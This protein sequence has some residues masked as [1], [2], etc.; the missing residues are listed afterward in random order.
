MIEITNEIQAYLHCKLCVDEQRSP[1][2]RGTS[3]ST[4]SRLAVGWTKR[5]LQV[6]CERHEVNVLH[7]DFEGHKHPAA[8]T[9]RAN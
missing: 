5:G 1:L 4:Y 9:R 2:G 6:W 8:L 7:V 3:P